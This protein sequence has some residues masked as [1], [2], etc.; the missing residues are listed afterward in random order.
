RE[1]R[2]MQIQNRREQQLMTSAW[3]DQLSRGLRE[4]IL[5]QHQKIAPTSWLGVQRSVFNS[6]L[7]VRR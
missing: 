2:D 7:G 6:Q 1:K 3:H 5:T 4:N